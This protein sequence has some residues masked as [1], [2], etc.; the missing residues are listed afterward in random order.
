MKTQINRHL[1]HSR[2]EKK[3]LPM[4]WDG[5]VTGK[6]AKAAGIEWERKKSEQRGN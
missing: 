1:E 4:V 3:K 2:Q 5:S 6:D